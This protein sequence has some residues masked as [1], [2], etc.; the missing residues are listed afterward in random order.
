VNW[1]K[2][3]RLRFRALI[4]KQ[5]LDT[6]MDE[7]MR[8]H[9]EMQAREN[10][11]AG[12]TPEEARYAAMRQF[13]WV[14]SIKESCR[15][16]R[17]MVW[18]EDLA[19]DIQFGARMLR[20]N[21]GFTAIVLLTLA[22]GIGAVS[23][24]FSLVRGALLTPSPYHNPEQIVLINS[25]RTD[26]APYVKGCTAAQWQ[27]WRREAKSFEEIA[28]YNYS[29]AGDFLISPD[30]NESVSGLWVTLDFFKVIGVQPQMGRAF[31]PS[32]VPPADSPQAN[33]PVVILGHEFWQR[34]FHGDPNIIG[35]VLHL[36]FSGPVT[37]VGV[38]PPGLRSL[39]T[40]S[41]VPRYDLDASLDYW[42]PISP[43]RLGP[44]KRAVIGRLHDG[45][46]LAT[47][48]AELT[49]IAARQAQEDTALEGITT[50]VVSLPLSMNR[51]ARLLLFPLSGA[52][53]LVFLIA[54]GNVSGLLLARGLQRQQE[55]AMRCAL[56]AGRWRLLRQAL[57]ESSL[58][59]FGGGVLGGGLAVA[60]VR[61]LKV[62]AGVAIPRLDAVSI[63]WSMLAFCLSAALLG[64]VIAGLAPAFRASQLDPATAGKG[65]AKT[66]ANRGDRR[67]L[68]GAVVVQTALTLVLLLG[69]GLMIRTVTN[70]AQIRPGYD[71]QRIVMMTVTE[72]REAQPAGVAND[73]F[74][75]V[76]DFHERALAQVST[77]P[78]V[79]SATWAFGVPLTG[80]R[81]G[82]VVEVDG[83]VPTGKYKDELAVPVRIV[84]P[85]YFD[86]IGMQVLAGHDFRP[87]DNFTNKVFAAIINQALVDAYFAKTDPIGKRF[88]FAFLLSAVPTFKD[89]EIIGV[90][91]NSCDEALTQKAEP[92]FYIS[93]WQLPKPGKSL[94]VRS[95]G[96]PRS[97]ISGVQH[98][99]RE[100]DPTVAIENVRTFEQ[101]R[102]NSIAP[103]LFSM[104]L[105]T[106]FS[107][108]AGALALIG[109][110]G[111]LSLSVASRGREMAIRIAV[112]AQ[113]R[114][115]F[116]LILS[117][118]FVLVGAGVL[119]GSAV[120]F[121]STRA[122]K[123][124]LFGVGPTDPFTFATMVMLFMGVAVLACYIPARR[125]SRV[126]PMAALRC[127]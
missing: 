112:G 29:K 62:I 124:L 94:V 80:D 79:K 68:A 31:L 50:K 76:I 97:V 4:Q 121:A 113:R 69:A 120:A 25:V 28:G 117:E 70:L 33:G 88:R 99:L 114:S 77:L 104:R 30:R 111:V 108:L 3:F 106:G 12:M 2:K 102:N 125:A 15:E 95:I 66:S 58:L 86:T 9:I 8:S 123:A 53:I 75:H 22:L 21:P 6:Q 119:I 5:K 98:V 81:L 44:L 23:S 60:T 116:G 40:P 39:P 46:R 37:V 89:A 93:W 20:K 61:F 1:L 78:G 122:L 67:L 13:G 43:E 84:S 127:E 49:A 17:G 101:I 11:E 34:R 38:M 14:E 82:A 57:A 27:E 42:M 63:G 110:Y 83:S 100:V 24:V 73:F 32:D 109:V 92:E 56:G 59:A 26:G 87:P 18:L 55:Y 45:T 47:A 48:Q 90:A 103:Q 51:D 64:A 74:H 91:A 72:L 71:T 35:Q 107:I 126:D 85:E 118:G 7:E 105:L 10:I 19:Q 41:N 115:V 16:Q 52:V 36:N 65:G 96:D 54:C